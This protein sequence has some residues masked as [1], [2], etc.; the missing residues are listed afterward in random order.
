MKVRTVSGEAREIERAM[1]L[2]QIGARLQLLESEVK[3]SRKRLLKLYKE[4]HAKSPP[5]GML[6]FST[7]WY[8]T[9]R[10]NIHSSLFLNVYEYLDKAA[11]LERVDAITKAYQLYVEHTKTDGLDQ[12]LSITRA[13]RLVRFVDCGML[14]LVSCTKCMGRYV[15]HSLDLHDH[16]VCGLCHIPNRAGK[17]AR[18][19]AVA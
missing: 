16:Y 18:D 8:M 10:A 2:I 11:D 19:R 17:T 4:I 13:W 3:L 12:V 7:D 9:W 14:T 5:K 1:Q 15:A 6:P